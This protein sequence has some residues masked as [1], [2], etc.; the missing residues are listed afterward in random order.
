[1]KL[2]KPAEMDVLVENKLRKYR[3]IY[4]MQPIGTGNARRKYSG[5]CVLAAT[6]LMLALTQLLERRGIIEFGNSFLIDSENAFIRTLVIILTFAILTIIYVPIHEFLHYLLFPKRKGISAYII[7]F[8]PKFIAIFYDGFM[9]KR[10]YLLMLIA[11]F[12]TINIL[13]AFLGVFLSNYEHILSLVFLNFALSIYDL[14]A[15]CDAFKHIP[16][17]ARVYAAHYTVDAPTSI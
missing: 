8:L 10:R 15:F 4:N 5:I 11:P 13:L 14:F 2:A 9:S 1:L 6:I 3:E 7:F 12:L 17:G 16:S